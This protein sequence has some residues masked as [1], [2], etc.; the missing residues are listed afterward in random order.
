MRLVAPEEH[1]SQSQNKKKPW[2]LAYL[3]KYIDFYQENDE[4]GCSGSAQFTITKQK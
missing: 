3:V 2:K 4:A 1:K